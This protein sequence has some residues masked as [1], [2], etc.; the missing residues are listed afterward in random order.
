[1][2]VLLKMIFSNFDVFF[3]DLQIFFILKD[4]YDV[5]FVNKL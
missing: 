1:M 5:N 4:K 2:L 3:L